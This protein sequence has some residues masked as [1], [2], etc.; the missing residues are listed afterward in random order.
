MAPE[1]VISYQDALLFVKHRLTGFAHGML[2]PW[3]LEHGMNYSMLVNLKNDK[4]HKQ[5]PL[6]LQRLLGL[7]GFETSP[8]RIQ[9]DGVPTYVFLLKDKRT[10][11]AFRQQLQFF[12]ATPNT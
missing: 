12:D 3:A 11:K 1:L 8:M 4:I 9:A 6:L 5:T 10:V 2:K 7:F